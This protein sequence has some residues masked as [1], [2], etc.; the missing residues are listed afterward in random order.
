VI[1]LAVT[2]RCPQVSVENGEACITLSLLV[3][4]RYKGIAASAAYQDA[5]PE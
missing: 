2:R 1:A 3:V 5:S 4:R